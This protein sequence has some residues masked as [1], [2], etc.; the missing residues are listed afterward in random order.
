MIGEFIYALH[1]YML[2]SL[3]GGLIIGTLYLGICLVTKKKNTVFKYIIVYLFGMY[4]FAL[5]CVTGITQLR[6]SDFGGIGMTPNFIPI[7]QSIKNVIES[8]ISVLPQMVLNIILYMPFGFFIS[9]IVKDS[10]K[11]HFLKTIILALFCSIFVETLQFAV[12]RYLDIDDVI[13]NVI[14]ACIGYSISK[15]IKS[16]NSTIK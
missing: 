10:D 12:G 8:G 4:F 3:I 15:I 11:K 5:L 14:G 13:L 1:R 9:F 7:I 2:P 16:L 6:L